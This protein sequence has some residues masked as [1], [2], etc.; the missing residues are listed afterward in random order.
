M[1]LATSGFFSSASLYAA[2]PGTAPPRVLVASRNRGLLK[3]LLLLEGR[4]AEDGIMDL[5]VFEEVKPGD[6]LTPKAET[7]TQEET[8]RMLVSFIVVA[9]AVADLFALFVDR[10]CNERCCEDAV[11]VVLLSF[12]H[13]FIACIDVIRLVRAVDTNCM[14][15]KIDRCCCCCGQTDVVRKM[16]LS[17]STLKLA[18][19]ANGDDAPVQLLNWK[20]VTQFAENLLSCD[21]FALHIILSLM[22]TC[23]QA[24]RDKRDEQLLKALRRFI[25]RNVDGKRKKERDR[26]RC[27]VFQA[28]QR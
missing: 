27:I 23:L 5:T 25:H 26:E 11:S 12:M 20:W 15:S 3:L 16:D 18:A 8:K 22:I 6:G 14:L 2:H 1:A 10:C 28:H 13:S 17:S 4:K 24:V 7:T 21:F 19:R 9:V